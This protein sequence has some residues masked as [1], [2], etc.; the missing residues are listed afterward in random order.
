MEIPHNH[1]NYK[2]YHFLNANQKENQS[3]LPQ[4][5]IYNQ[6]F[7][8]NEISNHYQ[9]EN[10]ESDSKNYSTKNPKHSSK[11]FNYKFD[12]NLEEFHNKNTSS[13]NKRNSFSFA[14][15]D[16]IERKTESNMNYVGFENKI[17]D[18]SCYIN[19]IL[20]FLY[21]FPS[22]N[23]FLI[24]VYNGKLI[25]F[26]NINNC[27][28]DFDKKEYFLFLLGKTLFEYQ[29]NLSNYNNENITV[30]NTTEFRKNLQEVSKNI[31]ALN[32]FGDPVE[33]LIFILNEINNHNT[34]EIHKDFFINLIEEIKC[35]IC[36]DM[37]QINEYDKN[38]FIHHICVKEIMKRIKKN[39]ISFEHYNHKLFEYHY[40]INPEDN[41]KCE[42]CGNKMKKRL[43][44]IGKNCPRFLLLNCCWDQSQDIND[45]LKF[46]YLLSLEDKL[47]HLFCCEKENDS[48]YN[49]LGIIFYSSSLS[50]YI[51]VIF[52]LVKNLFILYN[53]DKIKELSSIHEVYKEITAEQIRKNQNPK[54]FFYPILLIYYN[55]IIYNDDT[56]L[57]IN[58]Y[59]EKKF[60]E[61]EYEC[62]RAIKSYKALSEEEKQQN[63]LNYVQAQIRYDQTRKKSMGPMHGSFAMTIEEDNK[64]IN[65]KNFISCEINHKNNFNSIN[66]AN[67]D[68]NKDMEVE[69]NYNDNNRNALTEKKRK[70]KRSETQYTYH[71]R[72]NPDFF[73]NIL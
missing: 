45:V 1:I 22:V 43:K 23:D 53:D 72:K 24:K 67:N 70:N 42:K 55:E 41:K 11:L 28:I 52:N 68:E 61:L 40:D 60:R 58:D 37:N 62:S 26:Q 50:H 66:Q 31:Y 16:L 27:F 7:P 47:S 57:R 69:N 54:A 34:E 17:G 8:K 44:Y 6:D 15:I 13:Q 73:S 56:T 14:N 2:D 39:N 71:Y 63:Y 29:K 64:Y 3:Q 21:F 9:K 18:N 20:H 59:S 10:C 30:L 33:F 51:S 25:S 12:K 4:N 38:N 36:L 5:I 49:L 65:N 32:K 19:V 48:M 35:D 46:L